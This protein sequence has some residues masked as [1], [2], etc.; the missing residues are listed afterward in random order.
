R[1]TVKVR[2]LG[3]NRFLKICFIFDV[4]LWGILNG[5]TLLQYRGFGSILVETDNLEAAKAINED[6]KDADRMAKLAHLR[7]YNLYVYENS[8]LERMI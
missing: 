3:F 5:L 4:E 1:K 2:I 6:N 8:P 7:S